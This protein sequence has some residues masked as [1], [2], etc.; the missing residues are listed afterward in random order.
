MHVTAHHNFQH[1]EAWLTILM[2][3]F[4]KAPCKRSAHVICYYTERLTHLALESDPDNYYQYLRMQKYWRW[5]ANNLA[6][7]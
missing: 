6:I 2:N 5:V 4:R 1:I 3:S 7:E